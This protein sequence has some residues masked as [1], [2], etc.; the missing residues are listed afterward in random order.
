VQGHR[1][2]DRGRADERA[3]DSK[4]RWIFSRWET[5]ALT[6]RVDTVGQ[7]MDFGLVDLLA[8]FALFDD[9]PGE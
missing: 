5:D 3:V 2:G 6:K 9:D 7:S 8:S 4:E 1:W